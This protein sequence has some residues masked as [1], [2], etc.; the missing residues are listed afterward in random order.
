MTRVFL[1]MV[2]VG[3]F[4]G[5]EREPR[6]AGA[7]GGADVIGGDGAVVAKPQ[8]AVPKA[9]EVGDVRNVHLVAGCYTAGAPTEADFALLAERG[10][11][12][13][14]NVREA[15]ETSYDEAAAAKKAGLAYHHVP[16]SK[17]DTLT[18]AVFDGVRAA[19]KQHGGKDVFIHC[20]SANRVG[21]VWYA[22][23]VLDDG[24]APAAA[25]E[26]AKTIGLRTGWLIERADAYI[27]A[28]QR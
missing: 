19:I 4:V 1:L 2:M 3:G 24:L 8:A 22:K 16:F 11:V 7:P 10:V 17:P 5:C 15:G 6:G 27:A 13:V 14:I 26:E 21:A 20:G 23:R 12:A 25:L 9:I 28:R 18:D